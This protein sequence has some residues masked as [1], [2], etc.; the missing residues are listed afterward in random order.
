MAAVLA[1]GDRYDS[2]LWDG[3]EDGR[4]YVCRNYACQLPASTVEEL[5]AQ[6]SS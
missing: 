3:R 4:A 6:L 1:W 5:G 2:P